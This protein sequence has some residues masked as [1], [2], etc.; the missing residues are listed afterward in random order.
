MGVLGRRTIDDISPVPSSATSAPSISLAH[1]VALRVSGNGGIQQSQ[2]LKS[3]KE[4]ALGWEVDHLRGHV[5]VER[6][7]S[8]KRV[9]FGHLLGIR[10]AVSEFQQ[11][12]RIGREKKKQTNKREEWSY[13]RMRTG[14]FLSLLKLGG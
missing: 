10:T 13:T 7:L 14:Y 9:R 8:A 6:A 12:R 5:H 3:R 2:R 1:N 11:A 4:A